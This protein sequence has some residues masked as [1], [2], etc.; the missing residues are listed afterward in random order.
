MKKLYPIYLLPIFSLFLTL[1]GCGMV[2]DKSFSISAIYLIASILSLSVFIIQ[3]RFIKKPEPWLLILLICVVVINTSYYVLSV[4][5]T[6]SLAL[7]ANRIAYLGSVFLPVSMLMIVLKVSKQTVYKWHIILSVGVAVA[8]FLIAASP[9]ILDIYYSEVSLG[10]YYGAT[11]LE[12]VYGPWHVVYL[13]YLLGYMIATAWTAMR[14]AVKK[15]MQSGIRTFVI[16]SAVFINIGVWL[17]EQVVHI[18]FEILSVSYIISE[19]FLVCLFVM[20]QEDAT[21]EQIQSTDKIKTFPAAKA[22]PAEVDDDSIAMFL[23]GV[24]RLTPTE[25]TVYNHYLEGRS[26][27]EIMALMNITENTLKYH[28]KNI[29]SKLGVSSRKQLLIIARSLEK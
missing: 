29:Y 19:V 4:S 22:H 11:V 10:S 7:W 6:L 27:K 18:D 3:F 24:L 25:T 9:G 14:T 13:F 23:E 17:L 28:N 21:V 8:V 5:K 16:V 15:T 2:G 20:I 26:T 12:K 1:S